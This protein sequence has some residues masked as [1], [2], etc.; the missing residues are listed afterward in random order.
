MQTYVLIYALRT[1]SYY[2]SQSVGMNLIQL[3]NHSFFSTLRFD[4]H[5]QDA[6]GG[7][8]ASFKRLEFV[9]LAN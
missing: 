5:H 4:H 1:Y 3:T 6:V 8:E 7:D 2:V 9:T